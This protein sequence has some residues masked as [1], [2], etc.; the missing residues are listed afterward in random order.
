M[1][2][3]YVFYLCFALFCLDTIYSAIDL[4]G[5]TSSK[6]KILSISRV[7]TTMKEPEW[8]WLDPEQRTPDIFRPKRRV[9][10]PFYYWLIMPIFWLLLTIYSLVWFILEKKEFDEKIA[11]LLAYVSII[12]LLIFCSLFGWYYY[13]LEWSIWNGLYNVR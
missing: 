6:T 1:S 4:M 8:I 2:W 10:A 11:K 5:L 9:I 13:K 3:R 7:E 12:G